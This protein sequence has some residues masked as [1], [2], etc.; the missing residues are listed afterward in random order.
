MN[1][2]LE[3]EYRE[4]IEREAPDL[5]N[6]IE[7]E[8]PDRRKKRRVRLPYIRFAAGAAA[9]AVI[10]CVSFPLVNAGNE[11]REST[12]AAV[13]SLQQ[14]GNKRSMQHEEAGNEAVPEPAAAGGDTAL[15]GQQ[16]QD[17]PAEINFKDDAEE[18]WE[19]SVGIQV[20]ETETGVED[21]EAAEE[22]ADTEDTA[23][24]DKGVLAAAA[25]RE[26]ADVP[27]S[28]T[29]VKTVNGGKV[30]TAKVLKDTET[31]LVK[32]DELV[33]KGDA[34]GELLKEGNEYSVSFFSRNSV[35]SQTVSGNT[36]V[37][38]ISKVKEGGETE[39]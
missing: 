27:V 5:W 23:D 10:V 36:A 39:E 18:A 13:E 7:S 9:A 8:L 38:S 26:H 14:A 11:Q 17:V 12:H 6:R 19:E 29:E 25:G 33:L 3:E 31:G 2:N 21:I 28:V 35:S 4:M 32:G 20:Q 30:Y 1:K 22:P 15:T 34:G 24:T 16:D 37:Y